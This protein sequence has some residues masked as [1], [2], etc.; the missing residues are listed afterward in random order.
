MKTVTIDAVSV[1]VKYRLAMNVT[2]LSHL[3][4]TTIS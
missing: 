4:A 2:H 3:L 1:L